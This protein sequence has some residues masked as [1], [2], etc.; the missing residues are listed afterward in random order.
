MEVSHS[1]W[2]G[3]GQIE[4]HW[5]IF[6]DLFLGESW[7]FDLGLRSK[8]VKREEEL[9]SWL[10]SLKCGEVYAMRVGASRRFVNSSVIREESYWE[11]RVVQLWRGEEQC[12][13]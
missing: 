3:T 5:R 13:F 2:S 10:D 9:V 8:Q 6:D 7:A 1:S 4:A 12:L 11:E